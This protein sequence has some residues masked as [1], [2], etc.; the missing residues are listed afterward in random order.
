M[1]INQCCHLTLELLHFSVTRERFTSK[2]VNSI[3]T[4]HAFLAR[5]RQTLV[6]FY[7]QQQIVRVLWAFEMNLLVNLIDFMQV[8]LIYVSES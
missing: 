5:I 7:K 1:M 8:C 6:N 2:R 3:D 4:L